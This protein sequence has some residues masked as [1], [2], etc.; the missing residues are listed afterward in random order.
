[1]YHDIIKPA[2]AMAVLLSTVAC[3]AQN[4]SQT[5]AGPQAATKKTP[6]DGP[7]SS[8]GTTGMDKP[9]TTILKITAA[10]SAGHQ[11]PAADITLNYSGVPLSERK[12]PAADQYC[13]LTGP[14]GAPLA[15]KMFH[16]KRPP[17]DEA[18]WR[19]LVEQRYAAKLAELGT[20]AELKI[21]GAARPAFTCTTG[22]K[23][24]RVHHLL[25]LIAIPKSDE[26]ILVD[27]FHGA[28]KSKTPTPQAIAVDGKFAP[29]LQSLSVK[30]EK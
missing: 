15:L 18:Q 28:G 29:M 11:L 6:T 8:K 1:M 25:V 3:E 30:F 13:S 22:K 5:S 23:H 4:K 12:F 26:G 7:A 20:T 24:A 2:L 17:K 16:L 27:F 19:R 9:R 10:E 14:P 21:A